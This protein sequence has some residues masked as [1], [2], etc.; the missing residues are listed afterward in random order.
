MKF[1]PASFIK[2]LLLL[3]VAGGLLFFAFRGI[4]LNNVIQEML[5][6]NFFWLLLSVIFSVLALISRAYRWKLLI[7]PLGYSPRLKRTF[8]ALMVGYF[9]NLAFP[10]LGEVTRC[11]TLNKTESIP[12]P[13][14]LGTVIVER[15]V[16]VISLL[17]CIILTIIIEYKRLGNF[18]TSKIIN[19]IIGKLE[20]ALTSPVIIAAII[21]II[22][23]LLF[24][25][26][27][28]K[29]RAR[30]TGRR[31][32][33]ANFLK[34]LV[35]GIKSIARLKNPWQFVFHSVAIWVLYFFSAY[36]GL[37][38]L[39]AT[40]HLDLGAALFILTLGGLGMSAPV[41]GGIGVY[42]LLVSQGLMLYGLTHQDGLAFATLVHASQLA[43][44]VLLGS[45]SLFLLFLEN[46]K[47]MFRKSDL[48]SEIVS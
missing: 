32:G 19:P 35:K 11:G 30:R 43:V 9:A 3:V 1:K 14:L 41:Q 10:R 4:R 17:I 42:H 26:R 39:P 24:A 7:E 8:Y 28:L 22:T 27:Y 29:K 18:L 25:V 21:I 36:V 37:F 16:D 48:K 40:M 12:F 13:S 5:R 31:S 23:L 44:V 15:A 20:Y 33:L 46:K 6:A 45:A 47:S 38:A 2:F 34:E